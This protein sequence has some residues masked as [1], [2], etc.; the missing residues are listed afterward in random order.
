MN[1]IAI[2]T[3]IGRSTLVESV[4]EAIAVV[5]PAGERPLL[6]GAAD[7]TTFLRSV[8]KPFQTLALFRGGV[9]DHH[10][11]SDEEIALVTASHGGEPEHRRR[12]DALLRRGGFSPEDLR[13]GAH[14]PFTPSE[15]R[16]MIAAGESPGVL[17][18][19]CSGKH[20]GM[21]LHAA[22]LGA[23]PTSYLDPDHPVQ[24]AVARLLG[25]FLGVDLD[26]A[27]VGTDGCGAPT[28]AVPLSAIARAFARL[29]DR[30]F[31]EEAGLSSA[32]T[33][34]HGALAAHPLLMAGEQR[35][36]YLWSAHLRPGLLSKAGA[37]GVFVVWGPRGGLAIKSID[38]LE[39]GYRH[40]VPALLHHLGWIDEE[41]HRAWLVAD[42][43]VIRNV[44]GKTVGAIDVVIPQPS[45][46]GIEEP[47][48]R[49]GYEVLSGSGDPSGSSLS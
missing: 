49:L 12:V 15:R 40:A 33:R 43:P 44:V 2:E 22:L 17:C 29:T 46:L 16:R 27:V 32:I 21:L 38:G 9:I 4:H 7:R 5:I 35:F 45:I 47:G 24:R 26:G 31:V 41:S 39:R 48:G 18:N 8:A 28:W 34:L 13:C 10:G 19:N 14:P 36:P 11:L 6:F 30:E 3:R 1:P 23:D 37:E 42:P 25:P 20:A